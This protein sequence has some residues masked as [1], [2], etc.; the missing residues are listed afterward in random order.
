M[1]KMCLFLLPIHAAGNF[2]TLPT[3]NKGVRVSFRVIRPEEQSRNLEPGPPLEPAFPLEPASL[4]ASQ[5][6]AIFL[7]PFHILSSCVPGGRLCFLL[8]F[9]LFPDY[10]PSFS[11]EAPALSPKSLHHSTHYPPFTSTFIVSASSLSLPVPYIHVALCHYC[12][13]CNP[14]PHSE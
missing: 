13:V 3:G 4:Q 10:A 8:F 6:V 7:T 11:L 9:S 1:T 14:V 5:A 2:T 12:Q